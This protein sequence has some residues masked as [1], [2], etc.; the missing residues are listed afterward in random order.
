MIFLERECLVR[1]IAEYVILY[2]FTEFMLFSQIHNLIPTNMLWC[3]SL[4]FRQNLTES[5]II[6]K[7]SSDLL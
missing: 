7:P 1:A 4:G 5:L 6:V 2:G 3:S